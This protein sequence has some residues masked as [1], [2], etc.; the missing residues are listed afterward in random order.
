M[1]W[2]QDDNEIFARHYD[3]PLSVLNEYLPRR[4]IETEILLRLISDAKKEISEI[5]GE[6]HKITD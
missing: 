4:E 2:V 6:L 3:G 1:K 5:E